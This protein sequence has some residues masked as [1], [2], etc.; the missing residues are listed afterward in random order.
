MQAQ[1]A[2]GWIGYLITAAI[3]TVV[4]ALRLRTMRRARRLNLKTLWIVP[5]VYAV[6]IAMVL[7]RFPPRARCNGPALRWR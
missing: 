7:G 6:L 2:P 5:I 4:L 1:A 3:V